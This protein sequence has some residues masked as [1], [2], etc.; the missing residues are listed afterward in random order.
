MASL[1]YAVEL[2]ADRRFERADASGGRIRMGA[3]LSFAIL[4]A[5]LTANAAVQPVEPAFFQ[6]D[7]HPLCVSTQRAATNA[8][9]SSEVR[10]DFPGE[11]EIYLFAPTGSWVY[12]KDASVDVFW[13]QDAPTN[14]QVLVHLFDWDYL[15]YQKLLPGFLTPGRINHLKIETYPSAQLWEPHGHTAP[16]NFRSMME[17]RDFAMRI[18]C[19]TP[20]SGTC[21]VERAEVAWRRDT[22]PPFIRNIRIPKNPVN[23]YE[24]FEVVF[25]LPDRYPNPF[26]QTEIQVSA[27]FEGPN[28]TPPIAVDGFYSRDYTRTITAT[29]ERTV[30]IGLPQWKVRFCPTVPGTYRYRIQVRDTRGAA[31][32]GPGVFTATASKHPGFVRV[33][34]KDPRRY[35]CDDGSFFFPIGHNLRSPFD[36]RTDSVF[37]WKQRWAEGSAAYA[38]YLHD[39]GRHGENFVEVWTA[40][41]SLGLEWIKTW[42]G[43]HGIG[44]YNMMNAW[45][46]DRV[47][48]QAES[49][50]VRVNLVIHNHGKFSTFVD[51]EWAVNPFNVVNGGYLN[52]PEQ[53]F[54]DP[55]AIQTFLN[56]M[57]YMI[58]RWGY[59]PNIFAWQLW[60]ELDLTG[61][62]GGWYRSPEC[63]EWHR[64]MSQ[65]VKAMDPYDHMVA[66][67]CAGDYSRQ[68][69]E[70]ISLPGIDH[71][72]AD[73]YHGSPNALA[74]VDLIRNSA[75]F[76]V[77]FNKPA[78]ITEFG[79][80]P[81]A[82]QGYRH[83][84]LTLHAG[85]WASTCIP[86]GGTP[87]FW[88]WMI[89][90]EEHLYP[91]FAAIRRFMEGTDL[92]DPSFRLYATPHT[93]TNL[94]STLCGVSITERNVSTNGPRWRVE[95]FGNPSRAQGWMYN[96]RDFE[97]LDPL[98]SARDDT[99]AL[100]FSGMKE[101]VYEVEFW[102][103]VQGYPVR[104]TRE[105]A[106]D[107]VLVVLVPPVARDIAFKLREIQP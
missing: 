87:M 105:A 24:R 36:T 49:A 78:L 28:G 73:A 16:W 3:P 67:H 18:F 55:R 14:A 48:E 95:C 62:Q 1:S 97:V 100:R 93:P 38:R 54:S 61:S 5:F 19:P 98:T 43:Y 58:A 68:N 44:Q 71:C 90:E 74:I 33:S 103:T 34:P 75:S 102:D 25:D 27:V 60:S 86:V 35:E 107:A 39:M 47:L 72:P 101:S 10:I 8:T 17:P 37:P 52:K 21:R 32:W 50:G 13:P 96:V 88:W 70:I 79:G 46:L 2:S 40:S 41:W 99:L 82:R 15:W 51:P 20:Y 59:S 63:V 29:G 23:C 94:A 12:V 57:R 85:L 81:D 6:T 4:T 89:I 106:K 56:L 83:V 30:P 53:Y 22:A 9:S 84:E 66:T 77:P 104:T 65:A 26:D 31:E 91:R 42:P 80:S 64:L 7:P 45:E 92:R 11:R 76:L 69:P